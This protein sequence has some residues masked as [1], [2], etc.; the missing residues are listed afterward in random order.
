MINSL[1]GSGG[2]EH[3]LVREIVRFGGDV[4]QGVVRLYESDQLAERLRSAGIES[5][6]LGLDSGSSGWNWI[7]GAR[8]LEAEVRRF[9]PDI[10]H[11]SLASANL[12]AQI[13]GRWT[14]TPVVSTFTLSGDPQLMRRF[15]PGAASVRARTLRHVE[16]ASARRRHV[17]FRALTG[18]ARETNA[19]AA[20]LDLS[21]VRVIPRGVP[22]PESQVVPSRRDLGL[23]E[24]GTVIL[25][26]GRQTAQKGHADLVRAFASIVRRRRAHLVILG[27]VG[28]GSEALSRAIAT[29][30]VEPHV[31]IVPYTDRPYDY[32][33]VADV[34]AFSSLM[35]GLGTAVLEAMACGLPVVAYDIPPVREIAGG[36]RFASLIPLGDVSQLSRKILELVERPAVADELS[37]LAYSNVVEHYTLEQVAARLEDY[38]R[39]VADIGFEARH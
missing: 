35:E 38:L 11:S 8:R 21:R 29:H 4:D 27:R 5:S 28:D 14:S 36:G 37:A 7:F 26:V 23:P 32:Y 12:I 18:D 19:K 9:R 39:Q 33:R 17:W 25:N 34:F 15:Q 6:G 10:L 20:R 3:G 2:A 31:T 30:R 24:E 13:A 16:Y 1:A 22:L